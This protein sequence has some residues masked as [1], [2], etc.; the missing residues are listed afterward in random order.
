MHNKYQKNRRNKPITFRCTSLLVD[1]PLDRED[2]C[3]AFVE[4]LEGIHKLG[5][6]RHSSLISSHSYMI[7]EV[8]SNKDE[9]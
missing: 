1:V 4:N 9:N 3:L 8:W 5:M 7:H 6:Q 2:L